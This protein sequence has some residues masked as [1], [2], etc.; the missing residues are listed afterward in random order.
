MKGEAIYIVRG[1]QRFVLQHVPN[2]EPIPMRPLGFFSNCYSQEEIEL[3]NR[4][5]KASVIRAPRDLE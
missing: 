2:I 3:I 1:Q 4:L 5:S